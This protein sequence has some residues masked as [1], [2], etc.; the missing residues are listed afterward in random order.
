MDC[1]SGLCGSRLGSATPPCCSRCPCAPAALCITRSA[2]GLLGRTKK[3]EAGGGE[4]SV[5]NGSD[6]PKHLRQGRPHPGP[7]PHTCNTTAA[8]RSDASRDATIEASGSCEATT[9]VDLPAL[10]RTSPT[11]SL[12]NTDEDGSS[13]ISTGRIVS[14][15]GADEAHTQCTSHTKHSTQSLACSWERVTRFLFGLG[16]TCKQRAE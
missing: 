16:S 6:V 10:L 15:S 7:C 3:G 4:L 1:L 8:I 14:K 12:S 11:S 2:S 9:H 5:S 13:C